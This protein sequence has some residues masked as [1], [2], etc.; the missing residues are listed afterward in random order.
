LGVALPGRRKTREISGP[1]EHLVTFMGHRS[2][3]RLYSAVGRSAQRKRSQE[4]K[5]EA[6]EK[7]RVRKKGS[8]LLKGKSRSFLYRTK[9]VARSTNKEKDRDQAE[10][11]RGRK[12]RISGKREAQKHFAGH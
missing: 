10:E 11:V 1:W 12:T 7:S 6:R 4:K 8:E 3:R 2:Q 9:A 5:K